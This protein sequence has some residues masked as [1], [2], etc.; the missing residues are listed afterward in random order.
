LSYRRCS[1]EELEGKFLGL[2]AYL[3]A[4]QGRGVGIVQV[5]LDERDRFAGGVG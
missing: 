1:R 3:R 2:M 4:A 5:V